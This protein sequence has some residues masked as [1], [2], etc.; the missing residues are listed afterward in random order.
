MSL[1]Y[2][3]SRVRFAT[4]KPA[5]ERHPSAPQAR[6]VP[7]L[8]PPSLQTSLPSW[9]ANTLERADLPNSAAS[10]LAKRR[11][12]GATYLV[13]GLQCGDLQLRLVVP[14]ACA[15]APELFAH[16]E[17]LGRVSVICDIDESTQ[18]IELAMTLDKE[19]ATCALAAPR[20]PMTEEVFRDEAEMLHALVH[21]ESVPSL[22]PGQDVRDVLVLYCRDQASLKTS[23]PYWPADGTPQVGTKMH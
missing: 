22:I 16:L 9:A 21:A 2:L 20:V 5:D 10:F 15:G 19:A 4:I 17:K 1:P 18:S 6:T 13:H 23:K 14:V 11:D 12:T 7:E 8:K 3:L